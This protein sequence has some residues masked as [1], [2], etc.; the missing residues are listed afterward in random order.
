MYLNFTSNIYSNF[1]WKKY[2]FCPPSAQENVCPY[3]ID[4][5]CGVALPDPRISVTYLG[6]SPQ[7]EN[8]GLRVLIAFLLGSEAQDKNSDTHCH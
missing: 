8:L 7:F 6:D 3:R 5:A 2:Y 4:Y 1:D